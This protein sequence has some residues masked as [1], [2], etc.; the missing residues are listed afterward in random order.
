MTIEELVGQRLMFGLPGPELTDDDVRLFRE[1][2]AGGLMLYRRNF[3]SPDQLSRLL[4]G[5]E[6]ILGRSLLV[7]TDHEGGRIIMLRHGIT[8]FPDNLAFGSAGDT[9][10]TYRQGEIEAKE[11]GRLGID[12]NLGPVLDVLTDVYSPNIGIRSYGRDPNTVARLGVARIRGMQSNGLS[13]CAKHFPG[14]GHSPLDAHLALPTIRSTWEEMKAVHL[15]PFVRAIE[16]G[17]ECVMTSHPL[18]PNLDPTPNCPATFSGRIVRDYLRGELGFQGL[19]VS[20][21]LEMGAIREISSPKDA[22]VH[23]SRAGHDLILSCHDPRFQWALFEGLRDAY[24][25]RR[26]PVRDLEASVER[27]ER[28]K[29]RRPKRFEGGAP[30]PEPGG[31]D[32]ARAI[33][34][35]AVTRLRGDLH[36]VQ[37]R[38]KRSSAVVFPRLGSLAERISIEDGLLDEERFLRDRFERFES[39]PEIGLVAIE[40]TSEEIDRA[41]ALALRSESTILFLYDARLY[42]SNR[43]LLERVQAAARSLAVVLLRDPWDQELV[44]NGALC[45]TAYGWRICQLEAVI[46]YLCAASA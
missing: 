26:L 11:L 19:I 6:E 25:M 36:S 44:R 13:A 40:P 35:G 46:E 3:E 23:A 8:I 10:E 12:V 37:A 9:T 7:A 27:I 14:K 16:A 4:R 38:L 28:A 33:A 45:L 18:Y 17:V 29:S 42:P 1:S 30:H 2:H 43:D 22:G 5:L 39:R 32:L 41:V 24:R 21:D 34:R 31:T 15:V 20:D